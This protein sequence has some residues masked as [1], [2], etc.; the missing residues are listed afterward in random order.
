MKHHIYW[1]LIDFSRTFFPEFIDKYFMPFCTFYRNLDWNKSIEST[2]YK[3]V[4]LRFKLSI[5][6]LH[7]IVLD[8][9]RHIY[10][11]TSFG[12]IDYY[13][14]IMTSGKFFFKESSKPE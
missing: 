9:Y 12:I 8:R 11:L 5:A 4:D 10:F 7:L 1:F 2:L 13:V 6:K 14:I 3:S